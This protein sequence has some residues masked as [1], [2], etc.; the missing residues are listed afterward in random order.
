MRVVGLFI[1]AVSIPLFCALLKASPSV[2]RGAWFFIGLSPFIISYMHLDVS[3]ISWAYWPGYVKGALISLLDTMSIAILITVRPSPYRSMILWAYILYLISTIVSVFF[4]GAWMGSIF[5]PWQLGRAIIVF[6]AVTRIS[7]QPD[8]AR[9]IIG[10]LSAGVAFQALFSV[11]ERLHGVT[12]ASGTLGHQN[13]LGL[14]THF[15]LLLS[16]AAMLSGDKRTLIKIGVVSGVVAVVLTGSRATTGLAGAGLVLLITS[17]LIRYRTSFKMRVAGI[18]VAL[19]IIGTPVAYL[20]LQHRFASEAKSGG[21][22]E[23]A[24]FERAA[25]AMWSD[26][27]MGVGANQYVVMANM[28]GYSQR[29]GVIWSSGSRSANVHNTYLLIAAETG[30]LGII[31]Y[32]I[33]LFSGILTALRSAWVRPR[34]PDGE[35][36]LGAA[37]TLIIVALHC[38]YEWV[39]VDWVIQYLFAITL[40]IVAGISIRQKSVSTLSLDHARAHHR[41][42]RISAAGSNN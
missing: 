1:I 39:F 18:G 32:L 22:D 23:R 19:L 27:P 10:G 2:R 37:V 14:A 3:I 41:Q 13:L 5:F 42:N 33:L 28:L 12:Q 8:G 38:F 21:Y 29:A 9:Q 15:A 6:A 25:R 34:T 36:S 7:A 4:A 30:Y 24:A 35:I 31:T 11:I 26:H 20:T 40:G 16:M 17:S